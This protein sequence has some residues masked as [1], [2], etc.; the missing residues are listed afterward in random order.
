MR[1]Y[2]FDTSGIS[3][4]LETMPEDIHKTMWAGFCERVEDGLIGATT[5][6]HDEMCH[7][8]GDV[9][10]CLIANKST[11]VLEVGEDW[12]W[13]TYIEHAQRMQ[14]DHKDFISEFTGG[15]AKTI[16]L[17][18]LT[19]IALAK[20]LGLPVV[21]MERLVSEDPSTKKRRIPN[22]CK[23]EGVEHLSFNDFL[24]REQLTF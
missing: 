13:R 10:A 21:S 7:I 5:E 11:I 22:I 16:C 14:V 6:I 4:P 3:N 17:N 20:T 8:P 15:S 18:D 24:R 9:G 1:R 23:A 2:C 12:D 19:I